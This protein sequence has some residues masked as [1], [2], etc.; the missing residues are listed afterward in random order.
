MAKKQMAS[1]ATKSLALKAGLKNIRPF[2]AKIPRICVTACF[3][4]GTP[5]AVEEGYKNI[6]ELQ[7]GELVWA[8]H[9]QTGDLALKPVLQTMQRES[10]ALVEL[11]VGAE[12]LF[13]PTALGPM[14]GT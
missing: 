9:E 10:D 12:H 8:R 2:L 4:A 1:L 7:V 14:R 6:E 5:V 13:G 3:P 11:Q